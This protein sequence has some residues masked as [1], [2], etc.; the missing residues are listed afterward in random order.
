M[1]LSHVTAL[2]DFMFM[3]PAL[4]VF[5]KAYRS[6]IPFVNMESD[7]TYKALVWRGSITGYIT[8]TSAVSQWK[9]EKMSSKLYKK[10]I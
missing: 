2:S 3:H 5:I 7:L 6:V 10:T 9:S 4:T 1:D 8:E